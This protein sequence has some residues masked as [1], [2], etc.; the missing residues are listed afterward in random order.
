[1]ANEIGLVN[2]AAAEGSAASLVA[3]AGGVPQPVRA[4]AAHR[5][6]GR[7]RLIWIRSGFVSWTI[8]RIGSEEPSGSA[9]SGAKGFSACILMYFFIS[10]SGLQCT[11]HAHQRQARRYAGVTLSIR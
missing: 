10:V 6:T 8:L 9:R 5:N 2:E 7:M 3:L 11:Q 1:M 4:T